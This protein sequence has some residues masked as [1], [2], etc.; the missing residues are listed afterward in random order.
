VVKTGMK[1]VVYWV[2]SSME[3]KKEIKAYG[4]SSNMTA[5]EN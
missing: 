4:V 1:T 3:L 2:S 5:K